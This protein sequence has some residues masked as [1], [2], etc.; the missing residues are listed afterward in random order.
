MSRRACSSCSLENSGLGGF[1]EP[2]PLSCFLSWPLSVAGFFF[3]AA[4]AF[5]SQEKGSS[6]SSSTRFALKGLRCGTK[7][8]ATAVQRVLP[9]RAFFRREP[10]ARD[11]ARAPD[12]AQRVALREAVRCRAGAPVTCAPGN[13]GPGSAKRH[14]GCRIAPG[15]R[16]CL[17]HSHF[18]HPSFC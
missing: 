7:N 2:L 10:E 15:T 1:F 13:R 4:M 12:A 18:E 9:G 6:L 8:Y 16:D 3:G 11:G 14:E 17:P 5:P